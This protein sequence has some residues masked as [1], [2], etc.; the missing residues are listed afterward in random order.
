MEPAGG[1]LFCVSGFDARATV[2]R[3]AV[4]FP[5][6][7]HGGQESSHTPQDLQVTL[8]HRDWPLSSAEPLHSALAERLSGALGWRDSTSFSQAGQSWPEPLGDLHG[9]AG[10][11]VLCPSDGWR[12]RPRGQV[13]SGGQTATQ[14]SFKEGAQAPLL[15]LVLSCTGESRGHPFPP[16]LTLL[17]PSPFPYQ[18]SLWNGTQSGHSNQCSI[19]RREG[20]GP[21]GAGG[22]WGWAEGLGS[23]LGDER[24]GRTGLRARRRGH[25]LGAA[26]GGLRASGLGL[27]KGRG[28]P[29][30]G[31]AR[32]S[33]PRGPGTEAQAPVGASSLRSGPAVTSRAWCQ[34]GPPGSQACQPCL[35]WF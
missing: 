1:F 33:E 10:V 8:L 2:I 4:Q 23:L 32:R 25:P 35:A 16:L 6:R 31:P 15:S 7:L 14:G 20:E 11:G 5:R 30:P 21:A 13:L 3:E 28:R 17:T 19:A 34:P 18:P 22:G 12:N 26:R 9:P 29:T 27:R 24:R